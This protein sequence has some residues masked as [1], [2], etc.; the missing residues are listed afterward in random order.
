MLFIFEKQT[1]SV[2]ETNVPFPNVEFLLLQPIVFVFFSISWQVWVQMTLSFV[3]KNIDFKT[4]MLIL[5]CFL[6]RFGAVGTS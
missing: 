6:Q 2:S 3:S 4:K 5:Y 1:T